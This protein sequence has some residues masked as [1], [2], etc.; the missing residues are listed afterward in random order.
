VTSQGSPA[1]RFHRAV[2]R[3]SLINAELRA[4][5]MTQVSLKDALDL[6]VFYGEQG[7]S[8]ESTTAQTMLLAIE[9]LVA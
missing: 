6:V 8:G 1:A 9:H 7:G 5:G 2:E 3:R 4:Q